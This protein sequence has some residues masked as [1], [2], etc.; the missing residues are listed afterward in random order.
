MK[1]PK[2]FIFIAII[3]S[4]VAM[5]L[6]IFIPSTG[7]IITNPIN[8]LI[9]RGS[10]TKDQ[11]LA[12][13]CFEKDTICVLKDGKIVN[14]KQTINEKENTQKQYTSIKEQNI[15]YA[16]NVSSAVAA[17][18]AYTHI[19]DL[20]LTLLNNSTPSNISYYCSPDNKCWAV[21]NQ[22]HSVL[23]NTR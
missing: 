1:H 19:P 5:L 22:A 8:K 14:K 18:R 13:R 17:I 23:P 9:S 11:A 4:T 10:V 20:N 12:T 16:K 7:R 2:T 6:F 21:D 3:T 15:Q